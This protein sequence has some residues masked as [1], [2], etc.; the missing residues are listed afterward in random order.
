MKNNKFL[1]YNNGNYLYYRSLIGGNPL[2]GKG[3]YGAVIKPDIKHGNDN[4]ISKLFILPENA[5]IAEFRHLEDAVAL[6]DAVGPVDGGAGG[7]GA[8]A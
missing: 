4:Y 8:D 3:D 6:A 5:N 1:L 7:G 2:I